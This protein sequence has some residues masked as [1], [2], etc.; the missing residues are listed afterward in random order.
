MARI[1]KLWRSVQ[2]PGS[3]PA[4]DSGRVKARVNAALDV[5][6]P[7][8]NGF[9]KHK[10]GA[11]L[12]AAVLTAAI[13][14]TAFAAAQWDILSVWFK[15]DTAIGEQYLDSGVRTVSDENY[16]LTVEGS[17]ADESNVY[18]TV[19]ITALND[20]AAAYLYSDDFI[21]MDTF[22]AR[23]SPSDGSKARVSSLGSHELES[24]VENCRRFAVDFGFNQPVSGGR[25]FFRCGC[26]ES[27]VEFPF[28][29]APSM[30]V[31]IGASG[32]GIR[33][34]TPSVREKSEE[35]LK[36]RE[37][38]FTPF[39]CSVFIDS[40]LS[41]F[42]PNFF[43]RMKDGSVRTKSQLMDQDRGYYDEKTRSSRL[44]YQF[45][46]IQNLDD[47]ASVIVF[48]R[49]YPVD[50]GKPVPFEHDPSLDPFTVTR[51]EP[52]GEEGSGYTV[53]VRELT[54]KLG[55]TCTWQSDGTVTC[56]YRDVTIVLRP[57]STNVTVNGK[58]VATRRAPALQDGI[59][60]ADIDVF[61]EYW[62]VYIRLMR[63][64]IY[65]ENDQY[66]IIWNDWLV[67]P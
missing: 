4:L 62:G 5:G 61:R 53:P 14:G 43:L 42:R 45:I 58:T 47:I 38:R 11:V 7:E 54:E 22:S 13:T 32:A 64:D 66:D 51:M 41:C 40:P 23:V 34:Y 39:T 52:M 20:E 49:E 59:F 55:G 44:D 26:M 67:V 33:E 27:G 35:I 65:D 29:P 28:A 36:I 21:N 24:D 19:S 17:A 18:L 48:D 60:T 30:T 6:Q 15:G 8:R 3:P 10:F 37:I 25:V 12:L 57:G 63:T 9:M 31:K 2:G 56:I 50:G 46:E 1:D 16:S